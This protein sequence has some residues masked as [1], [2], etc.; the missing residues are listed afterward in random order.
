VLELH[1]NEDEFDGDLAFEL[2][3]HQFLDFESH[4]N[5]AHNNAKPRRCTLALIVQ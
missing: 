4:V 2:A 3:I 1:G 5:L